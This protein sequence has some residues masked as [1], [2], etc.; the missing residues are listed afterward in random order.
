MTCLHKE[1]SSIRLSGFRQI[2]KTVSYLDHLERN[3]S[4]KSVLAFLINLKILV[5]QIEVGAPSSPA[6]DYDHVLRRVPFDER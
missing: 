1:K 4:V 6:L 5:L 2:G 3:F